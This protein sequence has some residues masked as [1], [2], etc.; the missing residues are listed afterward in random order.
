MSSLP[1]V[2]FLVYTSLYSFNLSTIQG[3]EFETTSFWS[4][5]EGVFMSEAWYHA[6]LKGIV[7][8]VLV[9][10]PAVVAVVLLILLCM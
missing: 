5:T 2:F 1:G 8:V 4:A 9:L 3:P 7:G 10:L 6:L